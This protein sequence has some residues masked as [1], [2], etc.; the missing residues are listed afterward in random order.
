M[1]P[2]HNAPV[3][4]L[5]ICL[6]VLIASERGLSGE[7]VSRRAGYVP[8][9]TPVRSDIE[10]AAF[11]YP[12]TEQ[13]AEWDMLESTLPNLKPILGWYDE[14]NPEVID[15]QIKWAVE[16]GI[17]VFFV[18]WYWKRGEQRL[19]HWV[20][21]FYKARY[22]G[23]LKWAV[24]WANHNEPGSHDVQDMKN[25]T[26]YWIRNYFN[27]P[28]Y[29]RIDGRPVVL[30]WD[31][32]NIDKDFAATAAAQGR[33]LKPGE[34]AKQGLEIINAEAVK[35]GFKGVYFID[36]FKPVYSKAALQLDKEIGFEMTT[37]YN[38]LHEALWRSKE[39]KPSDQRRT[40]PYKYVSDTSTKYWN[41][42]L[43]AH[44]L[45]FLPILSTGW[46]ERP[47][48]FQDSTVVTGRTPELFRDICEQARAFCEKNKIKRI[49]L[50]PLNE[51]QEGS[52]IEPNEEFGFRMYDAV[53]DVFCQ[54]PEKGWPPNI[55]PKEVG[56]GPYDYPP[57]PVARGF[58]WNFDNSTEGW[59]R[60]PY[61]AGRIIAESGILRMSRSGAG[62][63]NRPAM[64]INLVPFKASERQ[65]F[66]IRM[67]VTLPAGSDHQEVARMHW[68]SVGYPLV[69][70][71]VVFHDDPSWM[72]PIRA[73]GQF[74]DYAVDL[75]KSV[76]WRGMINE[77]WF[78][79]VNR[80]HALVEID[81][82]RLE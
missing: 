55:T 58:Q 75:A 30:I 71:G 23:F 8:E 36:V 78:N 9:P 76:F 73:D 44:D 34:G 21:G 46:D 68:G 14:G 2:R 18:D 67:K 72:F 6:T 22:R 49:V 27:T 32:R 4:V 10:I 56:L 62:R 11:Y 5:L 74:H 59:H 57:T 66:K 47:R 70:P 63:E 52:Y 69:G 79:P 48:S 16:H 81:S 33:T 64:R 50:G 26:A 40:F 61:G 41:E 77:I 3:F 65:V 43:N 80:C 38:Y 45:P 35:A 37:R 17:N 31:W 42:C 53:R 13:R 82:I 54:K 15:W 24:M 20:D 29:Y 60:N 7:D 51:W 28:E 12:G 39:F 25:V 19:G 1:R